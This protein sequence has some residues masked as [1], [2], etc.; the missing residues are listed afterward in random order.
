MD[1]LLSKTLAVSL[2]SSLTITVFFLLSLFS[3]PTHF[4]TANQLFLFPAFSPFTPR[5]LSAVSFRFCY[6]RFHRNGARYP[7]RG[8]VA[9]LFGADFCPFQGNRSRGT[10]ERRKT[11]AVRVDTVVLHARGE[12]TL[13]IG[14]TDRE[15]GTSICTRHSSCSTQ[16]HGP[17]LWNFA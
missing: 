13:C 14:G 8:T 16:K 5:F 17:H 4:P 1:P 7:R 3:S 12:G 10:E 15:S 2:S 9:G 11:G 6:E